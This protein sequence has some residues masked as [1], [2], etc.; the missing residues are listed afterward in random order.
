MPVQGSDRVLG[1]TV[2]DLAFV[3]AKGMTAQLPLFAST[4]P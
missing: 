3:E 1:F 4:I 2:Y